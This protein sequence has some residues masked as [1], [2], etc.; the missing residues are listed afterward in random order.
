MSKISIGVLAPTSSIYPM[1]KDFQKGLIEGLDS[2]SVETEIFTEFVANG[3]MTLIETA[4]TKFVDFHDV[5]VVTGILPNR[6]VGELSD[7]FKNYDALLLANNLGEHL[8]NPEICPPNVYVNSVNLWQQM[9][10]LGH[11]ATQKF[12][13]KGMLVGSLFDM[14]YS[15]GHMIDLGMSRANS[16]S[17][18]SFAICRMPEKGQLSK[19]DE[20]LDYVE[21]ESPDFLFAAFCGEEATLFLNRFI[22]RGF[23][24]KVPLITTPYL[25]ENFTASVSEPIK[26]YT[27]VGANRELSQ[28]DIDKGYHH[29]FNVF[30]QLGKETGQVLLKAHLSGKMSDLTGLRLETERGQLMFSP[31][32]LGREAKVY[33]IENEH[34]GDR[35]KIKSLLSEELT[36]IDLSDESIKESFNKVSATWQN[37]Y[38]AV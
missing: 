18:W 20:V 26:I 24:N 29:P 35:D 1:S 31:E 10:S 25:L 13:K 30:R 4:V 15:F 12:G 23:H 19:P 7:K 5:D 34:G 6:S 22:E 9:W 36:T 33:L 16:E 3:D 32:D 28:G 8:L 27:S 14:G 17:K 37:P 38:L 11:W 21:S 2:Q